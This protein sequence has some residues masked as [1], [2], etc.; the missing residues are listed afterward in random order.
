MFRPAQTIDFCNAGRARPELNVS[1]V[2]FI[3][4][5]ALSLHLSINQQ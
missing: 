3:N 5:T 2:A 1:S 4:T